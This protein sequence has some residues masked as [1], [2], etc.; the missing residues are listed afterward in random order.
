MT[1]N[2]NHPFLSFLHVT[3]L[4]EAPSRNPDA[5]L[6]GVSGIIN[7][8]TLLYQPRPN[9]CLYNIM[10][11]GKLFYDEKKNQAFKIFLKRI[12]WLLFWALGKKGY[13]PRGGINLAGFFLFF[14][15]KGGVFFFSLRSNKY[16]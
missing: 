4:K 1:P 2:V 12:F 11:F 13:T 14:K 5:R 15:K 3:L 8:R 10:S 9:L 7:G 16:T 6:Y